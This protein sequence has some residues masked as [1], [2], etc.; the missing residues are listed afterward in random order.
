MTPI[1]VFLIQHIP[2]GKFLPAQFFRT[3]NRGTSLWAPWEEKPE[4]PYHEPLPRVF[5]SWDKA[6]HCLGQYLRGKAEWK[7]VGP[8]LKYFPYE[9]LVYS[10]TPEHIPANFRIVKGTL[11]VND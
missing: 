10:K 1:P 7:G 4:S 3:S 2:T 5:Y 8:G 11:N 9:K 6:A